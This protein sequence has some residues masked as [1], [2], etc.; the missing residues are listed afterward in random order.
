MQDK[1]SW[2]SRLYIMPLL[3]HWRQTNIPPATVNQ[4]A[5]LESLYTIAQVCIPKQVKKNKVNR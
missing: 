1:P 4:T 5:G 2:R 3:A